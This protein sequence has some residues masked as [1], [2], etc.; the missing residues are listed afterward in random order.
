MPDKSD[1]LSTDLWALIFL[2]LSSD[3]WRTQGGGLS[4]EDLQQ[5]P[6]L[7]RLKLVCKKFNH[8]FREH[9]DLARVLV[10]R[11][12]NNVGSQALPGLMAWVLRHSTDIS[13]LQ[14]LGNGSC[15]DAALTSLIGKQQLRVAYLTS[16]SN[17]A[18]QLL[19]MCTSLTVCTLHD[20]LLSMDLGCLKSIQMLKDLELTSGVF[21]HVRLTSCLTEL[22]F[23]RAHVE[24]DT[25]DTPCGIQQLVVDMSEI[26]GLDGGICMLTCLR[27]LWC[28]R[29]AVHT[30]Q[31][32]CKLSTVP[33]SQI[34]L[35]G[36][37]ALTQLDFLQLSTAEPAYPSLEPVYMLQS[38]DD[39]VLTAIGSSIDVTEGLSKLSRLT[40]LV[41]SSGYG[42]DGAVLSAQLKL[43]V[44]WGHMR[45]LQVLHING[46]VFHTDNLVQLTEL[47]DLRKVGFSGSL[48]ADAASATHFARLV[49]DL[50]LKRPDIQ[51]QTE[52]DGE[53]LT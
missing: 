53:S 6:N 42:A 41:V 21:T 7:H 44:Q 50:G 17:S 39:L 47:K 51:F 1:A 34:D 19:S 15:T 28:C 13:L 40:S 26:H 48:P 23:V 52:F 24:V 11:E 45:D 14:S 18:V 16:P 29:S 12:N 31:A 43:S 33:L 37:T 8:V 10:L 49:H 2:H 3:Q 20:P 25:I 38:L 27:R 35:H 4:R 5:Y 30:P 22:T 32:A 9:P 36:L 46:A